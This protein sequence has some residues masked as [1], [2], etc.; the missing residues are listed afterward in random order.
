MKQ[1]KFY[2]TLAYTCI[3]LACTARLYAQT[4]DRPRL[5]ALEKRRFELMIHHDT[6]Q[7][8]GLLADSLKLLF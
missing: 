6:T 5:I 3:L 7:L 8:T 1:K 4:D 2:R